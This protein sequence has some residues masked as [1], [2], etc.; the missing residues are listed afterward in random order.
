MTRVLRIGFFGSVV[1]IMSC[2]VQPLNKEM[3]LYEMT[4]GVENKIFC[5]SCIHIHV[6][7]RFQPLNKEMSL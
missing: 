3:I 2:H 5:L 7:S 4:R 1:S 6:S